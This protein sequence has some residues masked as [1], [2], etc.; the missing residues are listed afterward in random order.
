LTG[1]TIPAPARGRQGF[2]L[3]KPVDDASFTRPLHGD[4]DKIAHVAIAA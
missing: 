1:G 2:L 4:G 3:S